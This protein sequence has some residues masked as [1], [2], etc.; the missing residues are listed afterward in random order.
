MCPYSFVWLS[1]IPPHGQTMYLGIKSLMVDVGL[2]PLWATV[3]RAAVDIGD[4]AHVLCVERDF[5]I[6]WYM[7]HLC[8][9]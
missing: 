7:Y 4:S 3:G 6:I 2:C 9:E 1:N 8:K 5:W